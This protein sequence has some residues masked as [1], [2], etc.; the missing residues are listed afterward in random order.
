[1][2]PALYALS[3]CSLVV[4]CS[5]DDHPSLGWDDALLITRPPSE[6]GPA[7]EAAGGAG[8]EMPAA[9][10]DAGMDSGAPEAGIA[11][12]DAA[13]PAAPSGGAPAD[14][15]KP[16]RCPAGAYLINLD[17]TFISG[18]PNTPWSTL[19][20]VQPMAAGKESVDVS[21]DVAFKFVEQSFTGDLT[22]T[23]NCTTGV[24]Q[25]RVEN[26]LCMLLTGGP[27][28]PFDGM[29]EG[30]VD[31]QAQTISGSWW[32]GM[33]NGAMCNGAWGGSLRP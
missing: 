19:L 11:M 23:L 2:K 8:A 30:M 15:G 31:L 18:T 26:G 1:M 16:S 32:Y 20:T 28:I 24:L 13:A 5:L 22:G 12:L 3:I 10:N 14:A 6:A 4:G 27:P 33:Q 25:M 9:D 17:C 7:A 29:L 21:A